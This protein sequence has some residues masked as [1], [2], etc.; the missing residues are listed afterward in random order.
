MSIDAE[1]SLYSDSTNFT[2]LSTI[3]RF[4]NLKE[5]LNG[6]TDKSITKLLQLLEEM[7]PESNTVLDQMY[8]AKKILSHGYRILKYS[9]MF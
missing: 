6:W 9:C 8:K 7:F 2:Q 1:T 3:L 5:A 4:I